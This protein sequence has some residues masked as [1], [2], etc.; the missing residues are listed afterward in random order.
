MHG[1]LCLFRWEGGGTLQH[2]IVF[3]L[4]RGDWTSPAPFEPLPP[5]R[6]TI[7][8][9]P[10]RTCWNRDA[11]AA[12]LLYGT[13]LADHLAR[14]DSPSSHKSSSPNCKSRH[15]LTRRSCNNGTRVRTIPSPPSALIAREQSSPQMTPSLVDTASHL[16]VPTPWSL[17]SGNRE[18]RRKQ[19]SLHSAPYH[20]TIPHHNIANLSLSLGQQEQKR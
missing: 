13:V 8:R 12:R 2:E 16:R 10:R 9:D 1:A 5:W 15:T 6:A 4:P 3:P 14:T 17:I 18:E 20:T 7:T 11:S 19:C